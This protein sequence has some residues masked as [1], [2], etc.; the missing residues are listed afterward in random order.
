MNSIGKQFDIG[1]NLC[2]TADKFI[3][4]DIIPL[5]T[6]LNLLDVVAIVKGIFCP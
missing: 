4:L 3:L 2:A 5:V 6:L 1:A